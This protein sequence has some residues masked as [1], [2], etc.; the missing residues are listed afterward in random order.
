V[1]SA[2][3]YQTFRSVSDVHVFVLCY[4]GTFY[5]RVPGNVRRLG[6]WQGNRRGAVETL[7]PEYRFGAG[8]RW[9]RTGEVRA[10]GVVPGGRSSLTRSPL[11]HLSLGTYLA[12]AARVWERIVGRKRL[13]LHGAANSR[14]RVEPSRRSRC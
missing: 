4:D 14:I 1:S 5:E 13:G 2:T 3:A 10:R 12:P 8:A 6:P 9:L 11:G 7:K